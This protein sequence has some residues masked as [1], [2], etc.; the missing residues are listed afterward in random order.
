M[1][2][3][4]AADLAGLQ[5]LTTARIQ[6]MG[7]WPAGVLVPVPQLETLHVG[8][9]SIH[10]DGPYPP[11]PHSHY[12]PPEDLLQY[13][14]RLE[15][16]RLNAVSVEKFRD[17][18]LASVPRLRT[19]H[20]KNR[21]PESFSFDNLV[22]PA[23][24]RLDTLLAPVPGLTELHL[25]LDTHRQ[26]PRELL[27][28]V[29]GLKALTMVASSGAMP[30][31]LLDSVAHLAKL[32][33]QAPHLGVLPESFL[34]GVP[35]LE[36]LSLSLGH[37]WYLPASLLAETPR[38]KQIALGLSL[39][40]PAEWLLLYEQLAQLNED[41][42]FDP[43]FRL[44]HYDQVSVGR[45]QICA[46]WGSRLTCWPGTGQPYTLARRYQSVAAG[47]SHTCGLTQDHHI[48]CWD[49]NGFGHLEASTGEFQS[50]GTGI[51]QKDPDLAVLNAASRPAVLARHPAE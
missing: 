4:R 16:L 29:P 50:V 6:N 34:A 37:M 46:T 5:G 15:E 17:G 22:W 13:T 35:R 31:G 19:L 12:A 9:G 18:F 21:F 36:S 26:V 51:R 27:A 43:S 2:I 20:I 49:Q 24:I 3:R 14:P 42:L 39:Q 28:P 40:D 32:T 48:E 30:A 10:M 45:Q 41:W 7:H 23:H 33:V 47:D 25:D 38:L 44:G 1:E 8:S 11:P